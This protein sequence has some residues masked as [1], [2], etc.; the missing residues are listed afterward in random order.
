MQHI[1]VLA[2]DSFMGRRPFSV[3][4]GRTVKYLRNTYARLGAEP[5]NGDSYIQEVPLVDITV[6]ADP[7]MNVTGPNV[8][9]VWPEGI[10]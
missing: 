5:A 8:P 10:S 9:A 3:G 6:N 7:T 4:E 1:K 2:S